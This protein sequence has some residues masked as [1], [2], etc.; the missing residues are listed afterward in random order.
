MDGKLGSF[1]SRHQKDALAGCRQDINAAIDRICEF[2]G[3]CY[4]Y[5]LSLFLLQQDDI[6]L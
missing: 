5:L 6:R 2:T 1:N 4:V 3:K